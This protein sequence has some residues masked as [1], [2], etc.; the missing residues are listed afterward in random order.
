M[1]AGQPHA[2]TLTPAHQPEH[3]A[4]RWHADFNQDPTDARLRAEATDDWAT[5]N[6]TI[7]NGRLANGVWDLT[8]TLTALLDPHN[9]N[10]P[11][12]IN[13]R[14][15]ATSTTG[16]G[17]ELR[18]NFDRQPNGDVACIR[19]LLTKTGTTQTLTVTRTSNNAPETVFTRGDL[20]DDF[21]DLRIL[22]DPGR[23]IFAVWADH[24]HVGTASYTA[25]KS[26]S[27]ATDVSLTSVGTTGLV[28]DLQVRLNP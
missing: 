21:V 6:P 19:L 28:D 11:L 13:C 7:F 23:Q 10:T 2:F 26:G 15:R 16:N 27:T 20:P 18:A 5:S 3:L 17:L 9:A 12:T 1:V 22:C 24:T 25:D 14:A 8:G 4:G